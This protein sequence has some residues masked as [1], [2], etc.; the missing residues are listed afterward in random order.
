MPYCPYCLAKAV[1]LF[2]K[3]QRLMVACWVVEKLWRS[4][5]W[6]CR[7]QKGQKK[8]AKESAAE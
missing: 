8:A 3:Y 2:S 1:F 7:L 5:N 6:P 4:K